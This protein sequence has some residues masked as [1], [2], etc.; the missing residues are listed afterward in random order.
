M[1]GAPVITKRGQSQ[2]PERGEKQKEDPKAPNEEEILDN[3]DSEW[4]TESESE[5]GNKSNA[6]EGSVCSVPEDGIMD[7][8]HYFSREGRFVHE[9][10]SSP[11]PS[12]MDMVSIITLLQY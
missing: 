3:S 6:E 8:R 11:E 10:D 2:F 9:H 5:D 12:E 4:E 7:P 1:P